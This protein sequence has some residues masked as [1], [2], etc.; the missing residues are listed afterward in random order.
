[1][2]AKAIEAVDGPGVRTTENSTKGK[3]LLLMAGN[4]SSTNSTDFAADMRRQAVRCLLKGSGLVFADAVA[5]ITCDNPSQIGTCRASQVGSQT[6][7]CQNIKC[8]S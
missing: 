7:D 5:H 3:Q 1:M 8:C 6:P 2:A 4:K